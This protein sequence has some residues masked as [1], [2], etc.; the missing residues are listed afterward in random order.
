V[1]KNSGGKLFPHPP[2]SMDEELAIRSQILNK[3]SQQ[4]RGNIIATSQSANLIKKKL[5]L[6]GGLF[7]CWLRF[8]TVL[9][10]YY[11]FLFTQH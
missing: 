7:S 10:R 11:I 4:E 8:I 3:S 2:F 5:Y 9:T 6:N 1:L